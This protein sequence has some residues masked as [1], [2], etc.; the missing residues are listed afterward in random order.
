MQRFRVRTECSQYRQ[1]ASSIISA[2]TLT[3]SIA[4][5][6]SPTLQQVAV[7]GRT[8]VCVFS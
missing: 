2:V 7:A 8:G 1:Q 6:Q 5:A 3:E 4:V